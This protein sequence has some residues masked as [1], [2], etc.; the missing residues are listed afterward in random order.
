M[1]GSTAEP[2]CTMRHCLA[3]QI[4]QTMWQVQHLHHS[5]IVITRTCIGHGGYTDCTGAHGNSQRY[6]ISCIQ[7]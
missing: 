1:L 5:K 4:L 6:Y 7:C 2:E 3:V